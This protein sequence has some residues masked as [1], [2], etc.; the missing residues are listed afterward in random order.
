MVL[1]VVP[2]AGDSKRGDLAPSHPAFGKTQ[3]DGKATAYLC[4]GPTCSLPI[5]DPDILS[6]AL[7]RR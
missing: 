4:R 2:P 1:A 3:L 7:T 6:Q 5:T